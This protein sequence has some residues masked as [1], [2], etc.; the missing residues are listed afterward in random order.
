[1]AG[2]AGREVLGDGRGVTPVGA[3]GV[4][5]VL[6]AA[7]PLDVAVLVAGQGVGVEPAEPGGGAEV[8]VASTTPMP[9]A[10]IR[11]I[12]VSSQPKSLAPGSGSSR[13]QEKTPRVTELTPAS[14]MSRTSS[15]QVSSGHCSGL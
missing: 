8:G 2:V 12:S 15:C 11:S 7:P 9:F 14:R 6:A 13:A 3:A 5:E 10:C 1:M 4:R